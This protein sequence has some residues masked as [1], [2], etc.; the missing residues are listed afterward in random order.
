MMRSVSEMLT[1]EKKKCY[2]Q[3]NVKNKAGNMEGEKG[4]RFRTVFL[5]VTFRET[6]VKA[7]SGMAAPPNRRW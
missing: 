7:V 5:R 4:V 2:Q 1:F 6:W 3:L